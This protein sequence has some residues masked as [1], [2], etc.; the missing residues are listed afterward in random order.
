M[1]A[2]RVDIIESERGWGQRVDDHKYFQGPT[3]KKEAD[4]FVKKFNSQNNLPAAPDW[5]MYAA[6]PVLIPDEEVPQTDRS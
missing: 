1:T 6:Q 5:Y 4:D 2:Y 3:S